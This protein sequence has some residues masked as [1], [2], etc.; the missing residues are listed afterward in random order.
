MVRNSSFLLIVVLLRVKIRI[1]TCMLVHRSHVVKD[2]PTQFTQ[3]PSV[4]QCE[5]FFC[6]RN[7]LLNS[8]AKYLADV[9]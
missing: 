1:E 5:R 6:R 3:Q 9:T 7:Q 4:R 2:G 8:E